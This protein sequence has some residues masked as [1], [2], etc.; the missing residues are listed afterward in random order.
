MVIEENISKIKLELHEKNSLIKSIKD[1]DQITKINDLYLTFK[2]ED[3]VILL[4]E[5]YNKS[6]FSRC[7]II[8]SCQRSSIQSL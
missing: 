3:M 7:L 5:L 2:S 1:R 4:T 6:K 8:L